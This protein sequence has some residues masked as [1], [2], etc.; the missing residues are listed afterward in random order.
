MDAVG[1]AQATVFSSL[2]LRS[3]F[4]QVPVH[5]TSQKF[6]TINTH[7]GKYCFKVLPFG[8]HSSPAAFQRIMNTVLRGLLWECAIP[9]I[10]D[11]IVFSKDVPSHMS[12][13]RQIFQRLRRAGLK[14]K[15][16][17][18]TFAV[19]QVKYLGHIIGKDGVQVD[20]KKVK[21]IKDFPTPTSVTKVKS[22]LGMAGYYRKF[23]KNFAQIARPLQDLTKKVAVTDFNW[24]E[25][26]QNAFQIKEKVN[27]HPNFSS[28]KP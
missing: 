13:L 1:S 27:N 24:G 20:P 9:F 7:M 17:K 12:H 4:W 6:L 10:D 5:K 11:V 18:C 19:P 16:T 8:L 23:V 25:E 28:C 2:D 15:P 21:A 14:L 3:A 26:A 22:F